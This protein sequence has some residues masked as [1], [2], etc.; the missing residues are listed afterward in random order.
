MGPVDALPRRHASM[1]RRY[2]EDVYRFMSEIARVLKLKG[3]AILI[4]GNSCLKGLFIR[5]SDG[6]I[7]A[8]AMMGLRLLRQ[9]ERELPTR[10]R[11][12]PM[13]AGMDEPLGKRMRTET[14]LTFG[15]A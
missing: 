6:V 2:A 11:Y 13:P 3:K 4:V 14:I 12:L 5:N 1:V 9:T 8:A 15:H 10:S 7:K